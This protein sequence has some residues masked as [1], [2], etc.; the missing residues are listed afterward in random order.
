[1]WINRSIESG[2]IDIFKKH[3]L[4]ISLPVW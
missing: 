4:I 2:N 1:M 3:P